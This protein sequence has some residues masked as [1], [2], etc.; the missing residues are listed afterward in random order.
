MNRWTPEEDELFLSLA[1]AHGKNINKISESFPERSKN[2][3]LHRYNKFF[4]DTKVGSWDEEEDYQLIMEIFEQAKNHFG[5][6]GGLLNRTKGAYIKR[7]EYF[8]Q[9]VGD[10]L[11]PKKELKVKK[12]ELK[13]IKKREPTRLIKR[14]P[15]KRSKKVVKE[16]FKVK[17]DMF[18]DY[19]DECTSSGSDDAA[20]FKK[21]TLA[22]SE[23]RISE[24]KQEK[25]RKSKKVKAT[26]EIKK[27]ALD[28]EIKTEAKDWTEQSDKR[29][30]ELDKIL[31]SD[32]Q[33]IQNFFTDRTVDEV[34]DRLDH[35][36]NQTSNS[37]RFDIQKATPNIEKD[38]EPAYEDSSE[39]EEIDKKFKDSIAKFL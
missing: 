22:I 18:D 31:G 5:A 9:K 10:F 3:L 7:I 6:Q 25:A 13:T 11:F 19:K 39:D 23:P 37:S 4:S 35:L 32:I 28:Y 21:F 36:K 14:K 1:R 8:Q 16:E 38:P 27:R 17:S 2:S 20:T 34:Q 12:R 24:R 29:L 15:N 33:S 30:L 26:P